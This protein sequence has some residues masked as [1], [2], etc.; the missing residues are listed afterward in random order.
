MKID[1]KREPLYTNDR[2]MDKRRSD[3]FDF[4]YGST[5]KDL[6]NSSVLAIG[7]EN[8]F[9]KQ[10][11][12]Q[13]VFT[14]GDFDREWKAD[15]EKKYGVIIV[16]EVIE[17]LMNPLK[18]LEDLKRYMDEYTVLFISYPYRNSYFWSHYH[19]HEYDPVRF[20]HLIA[21]AGYKLIRYKQVIMTG[22]RGIG[23]HTIP[24]TVKLPSSIIKKILS[25]TPS[26][27]VKK[28]YYALKL[29]NN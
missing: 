25:L 5:L 2:W 14:S 6:A 13:A 28:Q 12:P 20:N 19:F 4:V 24:N 15:V 1:L 8:D 10:I 26:G 11:F 23:K 18:F 9:D 21:S 22:F 29:R 7:T 27:A 16:F 17:H 3:T